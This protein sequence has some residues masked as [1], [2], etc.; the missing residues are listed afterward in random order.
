MQKD[1]KESSKLLDSSLQDQR[2]SLSDIQRIALRWENLSFSTV[3]SS[4][5]LQ[6][7]KPS[8]GFANPGELLAIMGPSGAGKTT[9]LSLLAN[10]LHLESSDSITGSIFLN[11][12]LIST[13]NSDYYIRFIPQKTVLFDFLTP[14]EFLKFTLSLKS[15]RSKEEVK[16]RVE[17]LIDE[18]K[19]TEVQHSVIGN[20]VVRGISGGERKRVCIASE[21]VLFPSVLILDEP[22]SGLDSFMA[23]SV[24]NLLK[25]VK[26]FGVTV[27]ASIHQPSF[28]M[29]AGF[30]RLVLMQE[31]RIVYQGKTSDCVGYFDQAG[32][33]IPK[34]V[35][36]PEFFMKLLRI[37]DR[38]K[39]EDKEISKMNQLY[40]CYEKSSLEIF[41][42]IDPLAYQ[43]SD[44]KQVRY[45]KE[46]M[47][48]VKFLLW[49]E[50]LNYKRNPFQ[51]TIKVVQVFIFAAL[52]DLIFNNLGYDN[53]GV[54][55]RRGALVFIMI[56]L[57]FI[58]SFGMTIG[59]AGER[60][61]V[62]K[63]LKEGLYSINSYLLTKVFVEVPAMIIIV[64]VIIFGTY[65]A[66]DLNQ[67]DTYKIFNLV[68]IALIIYIQGVG[69][70]LCAGTL[71]RNH[72][73]AMA[74]RGL[75]LS[76][77]MI[78]SGFFYDPERA[79]GATNWIRFL[80]PFYFLKNAVL[81]NE[82]DDLDYD[83]DVLP[84]PED[85]FNI[86][87]EILF[88]VLIT[89]THLVTLYVAGYCVYRYQVGKNNL[90]K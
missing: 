14:Y 20:L 85:K 17:K 9:L 62:L 55:N 1:V 52:V 3:Q 78:F 25:E 40:S 2:E 87:G 31:G 88:N 73:E 70:G 79:P 32:F 61:I 89:F 50:M 90:D 38:N 37:E 51:S 56:V 77:L 69:V 27:I 6:I 46:L 65:F 18:L 33:P 71:S 34:Q 81:R 5:Q 74:N 19:L 64:T 48:S 11:N 63:E 26:N 84:E 10:Q 28:D 29:F 36:P 4:S 24:M 57:M 68:L 22:T 49:R 75:I 83:E 72:F 41:N 44:L 86:D 42:E 66:L 53:E 59:I 12:R 67:E 30:D 23:K 8:S 13:I 76:T 60:F 80:S 7:L 58:P 35:N 43:N 39:L 16:K 45:D 82:F 15:R 47:K 21:L 54:D